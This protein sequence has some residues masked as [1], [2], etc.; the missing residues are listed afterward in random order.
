MLKKEILK[1][2]EKAGIVTNIEKI[3]TPKNP[4]FGDL[5]FACFEIAKEKKVNPIKMAESITQKI[6]IEKN[7]IIKKILPK[8]VFINFFIDYKKLL[9]K[10]LKQN[11]IKFDIGKQKKIM[12]EYSQPNPVHPMHIGHSRT[13][14]LGDTISRIFE[15]FGFKTIRANYINDVG[16]QVAKLVFAYQNWAKNKVPETKPD[17]WL[18]EYYVKFHDEAEKNP[19]LDE[20]ARELLRKY[21]LKKDPATVKLWNQ[22]VDWCLDGFEETYENLGIDFDLYF[23]ESNFR[24]LGKKIVEQ[25]IKKNISFVSKED[26]VVADLDKYGLPSIPLVRSDGTGLYITSDL[27][28]TVH[29][30]ERYHLD[31]SIWVVSSEQNLYFKQLFKILQTLGYDW[32]KNCIHFS[33][34][35]VK[36]PEGKMSCREGRAIMLDEVLKKL[37][38]QASL[39]V[40]KRNLK[41]PV[42]E[43]KE[44]ARKIAIGA[45]KYAILK[46]EPHQQI[47]FDWKRML[48]FDGDT[49]PYIQYGYSRGNSILKLSKSRPGE[50]EVS[51]F[52]QEENDLLKK[53]SEEDE[54]LIHSFHDLRPHYICKYVYD[55]VTVFNR[56]YEKMPVLKE[57]DQNKKNFRLVL[58]EAAKNTIK[59]C[60][61]LLGIEEVDRM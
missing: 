6:T 7:S 44:T 9:E 2:L 3:E 53:L 17:L 47:Q 40:K 10:L 30:F 19:E 8:S 42:E 58:V 46:I 20:K 24:S 57:Q 41:M 45:L 38:D 4:E 34:E 52:A 33:Y 39:E 5:A 43:I 14:F 25:T 21:E 35:L 51:E 29:K 55:L 26:T 60:L 28:L 13:T 23:F 49:G 36:G 37:I 48:S 18:W 59:D 15:F 11:P 31:S 12:I 50:F 54:E 16:L 61:N 32:V 1:T 56:F 22:I 27:G